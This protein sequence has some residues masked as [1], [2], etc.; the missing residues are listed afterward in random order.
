MNKVVLVYKSLQNRMFPVLLT[1]VSIAVSSALILG[2]LKLDKGIQD[3]FMKTI[4]FQKISK[5]ICGIDLS[6]KFVE[7]GNNKY[8]F[9]YKYL[10]IKL[11]NNLI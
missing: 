5:N 3:S 2:V 9:I 4:T 7:Y 1:I 6:K 10:F 11:S 8:K